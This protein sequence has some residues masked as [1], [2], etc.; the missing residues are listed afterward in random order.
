MA[1]PLLSQAPVD[2]ALQWYVGDPVSLTITCKNA[3]IAGTYTAGVYKEPACI[4]LLANITVTATFVSPNT[5]FTLTMSD[6]TS[7]SVPAGLW[8]YK[9]RETAGLTRIRGS[10]EVGY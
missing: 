8:Y 6:L 7:D 3:N 5:V 9:I 1:I 2:L 10:V 4:T